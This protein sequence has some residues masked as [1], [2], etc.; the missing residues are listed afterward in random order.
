MTNETANTQNQPAVQK[1]GEQQQKQGA[2]Q[3]G[4][5]TAEKKPE[6]ASSDA[7]KDTAKS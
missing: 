1:Q 3:S 2:Q 6:S 4:A 7:N 5:G